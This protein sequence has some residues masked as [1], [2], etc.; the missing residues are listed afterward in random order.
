MLI[1]LPQWRGT[2]LPQLVP[3]KPGRNQV[4]C[5]PCHW[6]CRVILV[7][8]RSRS[9]FPWCSVGWFWW[10]VLRCG[11]WALCGLPK[12]LALRRLS[13]EPQ[14]TTGIL[15]HQSS[16]RRGFAPPRGL[17]PGTTS[18]QAHP[19]ELLL[20][21]LEQRAQTH[22]HTHTHMH[23]QAGERIHSPNAHTCMLEHAHTQNTHIHMCK[24]THRQTV[25]SSHTHTHIHAHTQNTHT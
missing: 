8:F 18:K 13:A 4:Q 25:L 20:L 14:H 1:T 2:Q 5:N 23:M 22:T 16:E 11:Q 17:I 7:S 6:V 15:S 10:G 12:G 19:R 9:G 3:S 24:L 21:Q